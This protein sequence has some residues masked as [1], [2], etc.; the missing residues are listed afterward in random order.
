MQQKNLTYEV[1]NRKY[2]FTAISIERLSPKPHIHSHVEFI[3]L[4]EGSSVAT[5]DNKEYLFRAGECFV[6]FSNQIHYYHDVTPINGF[7]VIFLPELFE[8][9]IELFRKKT[10]L[11]PVVNLQQISEEVSVQL[12]KICERKKLG[13]PF[14]ETVAKGLFM[15]LLGEMFSQMEF[16]DNPTEQEAIKRILKYCVEHYTEPIDLEILSKELYLNKDYISHV[17]KERMHMNYKDFVNKLRVEHAS[18]L[19]KK[20]MRIT[21]VAYESG[22]SSVRTF[23]RAFQK[24]MLMSPR[25]YNRI[26]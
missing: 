13:L 20:C 9:Y 8:D 1:E 17:F 21:E 14:H 25:E 15:A 19:L 16:Q 12:E 4:T 22:F 23:N 10:P 3:Y 7:M 24:Y 6:A 18:R 11:F 2:D 26:R 5:L